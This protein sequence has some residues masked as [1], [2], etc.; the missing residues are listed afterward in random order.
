[1]YR[2]SPRSIATRVLLVCAILLNI[3]SVVFAYFLMVLIAVHGGDSDQV[4]SNFIYY[5]SFAFAMLIAY[6]VAL[7]RGRKGWAISIAV[8]PPA[9]LFG[10]LGYLYLQG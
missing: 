4:Y 9:V 5:C 3:G 10:W 2:L 1:M 8:L 7:W 6:G